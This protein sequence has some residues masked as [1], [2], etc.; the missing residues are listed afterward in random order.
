MASDLLKVGLPPAG[1]E[2]AALCSGETARNS[3]RRSIDV[4]RSAAVVRETSLW[5]A[6]FSRIGLGS[7]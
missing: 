6:V 5:P 3:P 4:H 7:P 2:P 1:I